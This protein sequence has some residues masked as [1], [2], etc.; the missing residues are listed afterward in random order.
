MEIDKTLLNELDQKIQTEEKTQELTNA[1]EEKKL[2]TLEQQQNPQ[3]NL[4]GFLPMAYTIHELMFND[5]LNWYP[6]KELLEQMS[7]TFLQL[8]E[9]YMPKA[10]TASKYSV[11]IA[12]AGLILTAYITRDA[13]KQNEENG[14]K[15]ITQSPTQDIKS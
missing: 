6:K 5:L 13:N 9:K 4:N 2:E 11:E 10:E 12:Y 8:M 15:Q 3:V 1:K 7:I 14:Q